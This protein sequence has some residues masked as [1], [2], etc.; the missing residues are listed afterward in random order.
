MFTLLLLTACDGDYQKHN[1][2]LSIDVPDGRN[3]TL[4][5][6][7][8]SALENG[9]AYWPTEVAEPDPDDNLQLIDGFLTEFNLAA[10]GTQVPTYSEI[11]LDGRRWNSG[12]TGGV[13]ITVERIHFTGSKRFPFSWEGRI[14]GTLNSGEGVLTLDGTFTNSEPSCQNGILNMGNSFC[15]AGLP[16]G[17]PAP[18]YLAESWVTGCPD[19]ITDLY[20]DGL[21]ATFDPGKTFSIGAGQPLKCAGEP[22]TYTQGA[23]EFEVWEVICGHDTTVKVDGCTWAVTAIARPGI[24]DTMQFML[25]AA[26][27]DRGCDEQVCSLVGNPVYQAP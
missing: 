19:A 22:E 15:P 21:E 2:T 25:M 14:G 27:V 17:D 1:L 5:V 4:R 23:D 18:T 20:V 7:E 6:S 16:L 11:V 26:I 12:G 9:A 24:Q 10:M 13:Q 3:R 8:K